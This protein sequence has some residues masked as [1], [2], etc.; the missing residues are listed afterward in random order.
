[1]K[2]GELN[3]GQMEAVVNKLGGM[4]GVK[5]LL[6]G[7]LV[8]KMAERSFAIAIWKTITLGVHQSSS[9]Y[10]K[11]LQINGYRIGDYA[12]HILN[13]VKVSETET[14]LDLVVKTVAELGFKDG[15]RRD[16]IYTR[17]IEFGLELCPAEVGPAL[18]LA[19]KDQP[20]GEWLRIAMEPIAASGGR[21]EVFV[22]RGAGGRWLYGG[23]GAPDSFWFADSR[24]VFV[25]PRK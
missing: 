18:R 6:S 12:D 23:S 16:T 4:D 14:Q 7:E 17:A 1:M 25:A 11:A 5:R 21:L 22:V 10:R 13:K 20:Y 8:V 9:E 24:W 3:L 19:Y 2:Y 15:A